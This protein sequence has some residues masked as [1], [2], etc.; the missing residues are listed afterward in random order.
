MRD[1]Q[2]NWSLSDQAPAQPQHGPVQQHLC[3]RLPE[4]SAP[5]THSRLSEKLI[6]GF[7]SSPNFLKIQISNFVGFERK[8]YQVQLSESRPSLALIAVHSDRCDSAMFCRTRQKFKFSRKLMI[9]C[10]PWDEPNWNSRPENWVK[11]I[12]KRVYAPVTIPSNAFW[13]HGRSYGCW[14]PETVFRRNKP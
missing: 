12:V 6:W 3:T 10:S 8:N 13:Y 1:A 14:I 5:Q 9:F 7:E 4:C 2:E 11:V